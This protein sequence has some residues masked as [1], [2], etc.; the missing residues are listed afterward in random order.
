MKLTYESVGVV[1]PNDGQGLITIDDFYQLNEKYVEGLCRVLRSPIGT[2]GGLSNPRAAVS[3]MAE[4]NIQRMIY[5]IKTFK[6]IS[7]TC[8]QADDELSKVHTMYH[9]LDM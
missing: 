3:K 9:Q 4:A 5:Y 6:R 7:H 1:V 8:M 2:T